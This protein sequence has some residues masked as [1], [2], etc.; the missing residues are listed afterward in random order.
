MLRILKLGSGKGAG[1]LTAS[2]QVHMRA[3]AILWG[4]GTRFRSGLEAGFTNLRFS[5]FSSLCPDKCWYSTSN[6]AT[7]FP[8]NYSQSTNT[9]QPELLTAS[10]KY[11]QKVLNFKFPLH[12]HR[13]H[14]EGVRSIFRS[15]ALRLTDCISVIPKVNWA[16]SDL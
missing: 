11:S 2:R 16:R 9:M 8:F 5:W 4:G 1:T 6:Y 13:P 7:N 10:L 14:K 3:A 12:T 15:T